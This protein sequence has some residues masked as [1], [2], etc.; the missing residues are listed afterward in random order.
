ML[1][2]TTEYHLKGTK[3]TNSYPLN[4]KFFNFV[5]TCGAESAERVVSKQK[6]A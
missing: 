4:E 1:S 2:K 3:K 5:V 6:N